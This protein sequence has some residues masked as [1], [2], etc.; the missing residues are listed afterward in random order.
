MVMLHI[1]LKGM[2]LTITYKQIFCSYTYPG[3]LVWGQKV[4]LFSFLKVVMLHNQI[5]WNEA[6]NTM[7]A[8]ILPFYT[9]LTPVWG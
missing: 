8:N 1:K 4:N 6:Y 7:H 5:S 3:P 2:E 9:L